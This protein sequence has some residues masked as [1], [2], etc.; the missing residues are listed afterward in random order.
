L[1]KALI[2]GSTGIV[3]GNL[4]RHLLDAGDW[5]VAGLARHPDALGG[6]IETIQADLT[7]AKSV[8]TALDGLNP[9][10]VFFC[11]WSRRATEAENCAVNSAMVRNVLNAKVSGKLEHVALVTGTKHYLGPFESYGKRPVETPFHEDQPRLDIQNFYYA[12][13]DEVF[14]AAGR[15]GFSWSVHR[16]HTIVGFAVGN[17]M[18]MASTIGAY[19][20]IAK[21]TGM[22]FVFP[23]SPTQYNG[24][25]DVTDA[26]LLARHLEWAAITD[27]ARN[28]PFNVVNG[29]VFR[30]RWLWPRIA[31]Y[32]GITPAEYGGSPTSLEAEMRDASPVWDGIVSKHKLQANPISRVASWWHTDADLG[33]PVEVF[34]DMANSRRLGFHEFQETLASF[35]A[36]FER[37][38][39]SGVLP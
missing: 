9:T 3:G 32:F 26:R 14:A 27:A 34:N 30:W 37:L 19:A 38:R 31:E 22:P 4:A 13:E 6:E 16:P 24:I 15:D 23:G 21:E 35:L 33:R 17:V 20:A 18:N 7:D 39:A 25:T 29:D 12:Q 1:R 11:T 10:H 2:V 5:Q 36:V 28:H 8:A